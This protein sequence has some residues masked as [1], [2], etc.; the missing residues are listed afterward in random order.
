MKFRG[1]KILPEDTLAVTFHQIVLIIIYTV[2]EN[3]VAPVHTKNSN[4]KAKQITSYTTG[5]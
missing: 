2:H 3:K 1:E 5:S 4:G